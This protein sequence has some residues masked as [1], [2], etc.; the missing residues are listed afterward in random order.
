MSRL[1]IDE[2]QINRMIREREEARGKKDWKRADEIRASLASMG[3]S[4]E[5]GSIGTTWKIKGD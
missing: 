3:I 5:D 2:D 1:R 4:V